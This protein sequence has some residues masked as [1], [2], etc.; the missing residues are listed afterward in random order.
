M[1]NVV[2]LDAHR[3]RK[4]ARAWNELNC[5]FTRSLLREATTL[6]R[7]HFPD[8]KLRDAWVYRFNGD[9]W[10]FH[11]PDDFYWHGDADGAYHARYKGWMAWL[12]RKGV[13]LD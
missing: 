4:D 3:N 9:H 13:A 12:E 1:G 2:S 5:I 7:S 8:V 6:V 10:E 11:G